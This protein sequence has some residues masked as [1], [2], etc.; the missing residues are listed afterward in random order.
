MGYV[1]VFHLPYRHDKSDLYLACIR[2]YSIIRYIK[3]FC[4]TT[5]TIALQI[6]NNDFN[7]NVRHLVER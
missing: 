6:L 5:V 2:L 3:L 1:F 7:L 4:R